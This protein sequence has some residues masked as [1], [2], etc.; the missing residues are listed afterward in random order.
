MSFASTT[1]A[2][3]TA[4]SKQVRLA[5]VALRD[6]INSTSLRGVRNDV[7]DDGIDTILQN[8]ANAIKAAGYTAV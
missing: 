1:Q 4:V 8:L 2:N 5:E 6:T 7:S 3:R